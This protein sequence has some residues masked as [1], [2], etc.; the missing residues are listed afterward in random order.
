[1]RVRL[2]SISTISMR[3]GEWRDGSTRL[4]GWTGEA[5]MAGCGLEEEEGRRWRGSSRGE[6]AGWGGHGRTRCL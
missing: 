4:A 2:N 6:A 3:A 1:M 5:S